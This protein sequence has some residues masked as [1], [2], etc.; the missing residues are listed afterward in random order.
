M[1]ILLDNPLATMSGPYFLIFY[2]FTIFFTLA[3]FG[4]AKS[5]IDKTDN[6]ILPPISSN[7]DPYEI[8]F[9]RGGT[10][11]VARTAVFALISKKLLAIEE[12][13]GKKYLQR[14]T[15]PET[16]RLVPIE[17]ISLD[18]AADGRAAAD[19]FKANGLIKQLEAYGITY[20][21]RLEQG[22]LLV[23][24]DMRARLSRGKR[25]ALAI[26]VGVGLYKLGAAL[27]FG[28]FNVA[29]II[30]MLIVGSLI[31]RAFFGMPRLTKLGRAYL[32][33]LQLAF[34][35]LKFASRQP[36]V[37]TGESM[38]RGEP[39]LAAV[40]PLLL[41]VGLFGGAA[42]AGTVFDSYNQ[43]FQK[44]QHS[45]GVSGSSCSS[46]CGS[47]SSSDSGGCSSGSSCS[48]GC[49]GGCGGCGG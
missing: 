13:K 2:G 5:R 7:V 1:E 39:A 34:D 17:R 47:C 40:D 45:A 38:R 16:E 20:Q 25:I 9:L 19:V 11:E 31:A 41:S 8:A 10:N 26:I 15:E 48:S 44:A 3:I 28:A 21:A 6:L 23:G 33:R 36:A 49:G 22:Q 42:L 4:I 14:T 35:D 37:S 43:T 32:E 46:G 24:A 29:G 30:I 27:I 12:V 18:W